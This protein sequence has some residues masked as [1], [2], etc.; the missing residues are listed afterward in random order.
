VRFELTRPFGLPVFKTGAI[1]RSATPPAVAGSVDAGRGQRPRLQRAIARMMSKP[2][3][4]S[5]VLPIAT[6]PAEKFFEP[7]DITAV[8]TN[9]IL[10]FAIGHLA[11]IRSRTGFDIVKIFNGS[12]LRKSQ[13]AS[14][15]FARVAAKVLELN[16]VNLLARKVSEHSLHLLCVKAAIRVGVFAQ[17]EGQR[18]SRAIFFLL[19]CREKI[20]ILQTAISL[21]VPVGE[22]SV[23]WIPQQ[24]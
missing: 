24:D 17:L 22:C 5:H 11:S 14:S 16:Y 18:F 9:K 8:N 10:S 1:N 23:R 4:R 6:I 15:V 19:H 20:K 7:L 13:T 3:S 2:A 21:H 12:T